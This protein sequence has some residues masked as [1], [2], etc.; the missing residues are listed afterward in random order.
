MHNW[1]RNFLFNRTITVR[2]G[3]TFSQ[4]HTIDNGT[5]QGGVSNPVL[6]NLMIDYIFTM[7]DSGIGR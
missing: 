2:M 5:P 4:I 6:F 1:I 7:V 3:T